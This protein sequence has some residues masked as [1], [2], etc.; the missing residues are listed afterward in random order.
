M[1]KGMKRWPTYETLSLT[2]PWGAV[3]KDLLSAYS[4][5]KDSEPNNAKKYTSSF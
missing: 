2:K 1:L 3:G 4:K 5:T